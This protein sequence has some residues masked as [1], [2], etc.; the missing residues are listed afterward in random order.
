MHYISLC[1]SIRNYI[2]RA[3]TQRINIQVGLTLSHLAVVR[4]ISISGSW[5]TLTAETLSAL[6]E[7]VYTRR[8]SVPLDCIIKTSL[9]LE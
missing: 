9:V 6:Y 2:S 1:C 3:I 7:E 4:E 8:Y 5:T